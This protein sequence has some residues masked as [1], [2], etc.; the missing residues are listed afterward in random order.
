M[1]R[2]DEILGP[3]SGH[4]RSLGSA[5]KTTPIPQLEA[6]S[7]GRAHRVKRPGRMQRSRLDEG[8]NESHVQCQQRKASETRKCAGP[9]ETAALVTSSESGGL[10]SLLVPA[11]AAR[12]LAH[13]G[14]PVLTPRP[15][16]GRVQA[17]PYAHL[18]S[19]STS[20]ERPPGAAG[21][22]AS[23]SSSSDKKG[24]GLQSRLSEGPAASNTLPGAAGT[25]PW[26]PGCRHLIWTRW[27]LP[28]LPLPQVWGRT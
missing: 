3:K 16:E 20:R 1:C 2:V 13:E 5:V 17:H 27:A 25:A 14:R 24:L 6:H 9:Q 28:S 10:L 4:R 22:T 11:D 8:T 15:S 21:L 23:S 26:L 12:G 19:P 7:P 18:L